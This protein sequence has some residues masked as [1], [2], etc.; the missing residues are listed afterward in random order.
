M[1]HYAGIQEAIQRVVLA[2]Q[3]TLMANFDIKH[4][5][6]ISPVSAQDRNFFGMKW[7]DINHVD[8]AL[9]FGISPAD[10]YEIRG[11]FGVHSLSRV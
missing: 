9:P 1:V 2:G 6:R 4:A 8:L 7:R 3:G 11:C 10:F 5:Y